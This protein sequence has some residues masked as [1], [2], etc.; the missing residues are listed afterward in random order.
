AQYKL[1]PE[2][3]NY[4]NQNGM[5]TKAIRFITIGGFVA[6]WFGREMIISGSYLG[7][8]VYEYFNDQV[9][10]RDKIVTEYNFN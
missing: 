10:G 2:K 9:T 4:E 7:I 8:C 3:Y 5:Y 6:P 1:V